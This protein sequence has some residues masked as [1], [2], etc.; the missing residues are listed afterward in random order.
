MARRIWI[1]A[2]STLI[3]LTVCWF[4][5]SRI[6]TFDTGLLFTDWVW[7]VP[8]T[9]FAALI[10]RPYWTIV[11]A[12]LTAGGVVVMGH[13]GSV[14]VEMGRAWSVSDLC[15]GIGLIGCIVALSAQL[16]RIFPDAL[17]EARV[18]GRRARGGAELE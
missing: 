14:A 4:A 6:A 1:Y 8:T 10:M 7:L 15:A 16:I 3:T 18:L 5:D 13:S 2:G 17:A 9:F 12:G 11:F